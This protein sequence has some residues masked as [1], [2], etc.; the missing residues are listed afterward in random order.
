MT[1]I[2]IAT[3]PTVCNRARTQSKTTIKR[4]SFYLFQPSQMTSTITPAEL[5]I[6]INKATNESIPNGD[7]DL[8]TS[9]EISDII[10]SKRIPPKDAMRCLQKRIAN[11][12]MN[13]NTQLSTWRLVEVC[14]KNG[15]TPFIVEVCSREFMNTFEKTILQNEDTDESDDE[16]GTLVKTLFMELYGT[17]KNDSQL[18][19]VAKV[20]DKLKNRNV[21]LPKVVLGNGIGNAMFDSKTPADW[22]ES[23]TC[24]VCS[25]KFSLLN[26]RHHCRSCG[27]IFCQEHS[28][29]NIELPDLG[30][31][32]P[33]RVCDNCFD[34]YD[35]KKSKPSSKKKKKDKSKHRHN[36]K[37]PK[38]Q[39][40]ADEEDEQLKRAIELSLKEARNSTEPIVPVVTHTTEEPILTEEEENDPDLKAA[41]EASLRESQEAEQRRN[42]MNQ[43]AYNTHQERQYAQQQQQQQQHSFDLNNAEKEDIYL[44]ATLVEKAKNNP[45]SA[46]DILEDTRLQKLYQKIMSTKPKLN[47][48]LNDKIN[49]YNAL[50]D[51]NSKIS[52]IMN[53]YDSL[54]EQQLRNINLSQQYSVAQEPSDPYA[55]Y[56]QQQQEPP[57]I[58]TDPTVATTKPIIESYNNYYQTAS[59][60]IQNPA[61]YQPSQQVEHQPPSRVQEEQAKFQ[62][63]NETNIS[64]EPSEP[65][66]P[67]DEMTS[68]P[69]GNEV[70][71][72]IETISN[73]LPYSSEVVSDEKSLN[74]ENTSTSVTPNKVIT[75][76][77]ANVPTLEEKTTKNDAITNY[78]FPT[79][80]ARKLP[81]P[82]TGTETANKTEYQAS[83][84]VEEE[85]EEEPKEEEL[86]IEL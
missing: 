42:E 20:H 76:E 67:E 82:E 63:N 9:F 4:Q 1:T 52:S 40:V 47:N 65:P 34:D 60:A 74:K 14:I 19:Y 44:F 54:L 69:S 61:H 2:L 75:E 71:T 56:T 84:D 48:A 5:D 27:G 36:N 46:I 16:L 22:I 32:E 37:H 78:D 39:N 72:S 23:D 21:D 77:K 79:V 13:P 66:Y 8:P 6:L 17:F 70:I 3:V 11:T 49:K 83:Q 28:S 62:Y 7:L 53:I 10:R 55:M 58:R 68:K 41:I 43:S 29:H 33:V 81:Y 85:H 12:Y 51:M 18:G 26:R 73:P 31:Y 15:G 59:P 86:L 35:I 57:L 64:L 24:M 45:N 25:K 38:H 30:I 50:I 80:P